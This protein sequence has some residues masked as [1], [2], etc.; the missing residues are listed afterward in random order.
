MLI[1]MTSFYP[2]KNI[3]KNKIKSIKNIDFQCACRSSVLFIKTDKN[4]IPV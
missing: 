2:E 1:F 3:Y 4:Y